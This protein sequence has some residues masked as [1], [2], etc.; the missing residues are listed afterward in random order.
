[1]PSPLC[2]VYHTRTLS[3][4]SE[5]KTRKQAEAERIKAG[6]ECGY[7]ARNK[8]VTTSRFDTKAFR[9]AY[10]FMYND[11]CKPQTVQRFTVSAVA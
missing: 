4:R 7:I 3:A 11:F 9:A 1:M 8:A 6:A 10:E 2:S 5:L